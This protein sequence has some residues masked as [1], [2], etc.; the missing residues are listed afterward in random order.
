M[1]YGNHVFTIIFIHEGAWK[2]AETA[3]YILEQFKLCLWAFL[4]YSATLKSISAQS[5][6]EGI[7]CAK[8]S[9][10]VPQLMEGKGVEK[11]SRLTLKNHQLIVKKIGVAHLWKS[12]TYVLKVGTSLEIINLHFKR[13]PTSRNHQHIV[14]H[15]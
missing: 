14:V 11:L 6:Q 8:Q 15:R 3:V 5:S 9:S 4:A 12:S 7:K 13:W 1:G 10:E 2:H